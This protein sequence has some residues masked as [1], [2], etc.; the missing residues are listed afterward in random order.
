MIYLIRTAHLVINDDNT[1]TAV[2]VLKIGYSSDPTGESRFST[3]RNNGPIMILA[4]ISDGDRELERMLHFHFENLRVYGNEW[5]SDSAEIIEFFSNCKTKKEMLEALDKSEEGIV[6]IVES[7][8]YAKY[9]KYRTTLQYKIDKD[10]AN[11]GDKFPELLSYAKEFYS[12]G[13]YEDRLKYLCTEIPEDQRINFARMITTDDSYLSFLE[14]LSL[15][16]IKELRY[17]RCDLFLELDKTL[18]NLS[19]EDKVKLAVLDAFVVGEVYTTFDIKETLKSIF[20]RF[21]YR[22]NPKSTTLLN[23]FYLKESKADSRNG[24]FKTRAYR[25]MS[26]KE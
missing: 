4:K 9:M 21:D 1:F 11:I 25:I 24:N 18:Q 7:G 5:Y 3:Y 15:S 22:K 12:L 26:V 16:I 17:R 2:P 23:Y 20:I 6:S 19:V 8:N 14:N 10:V 13:R